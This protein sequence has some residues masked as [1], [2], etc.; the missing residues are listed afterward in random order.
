MLYDQ[1]LLIVI[2]VVNNS[3]NNL[4]SINSRYTKPNPYILLPSD[5]LTFGFQLP[6][7]ND[8]GIAQNSLTFATTGINKITLYGSSLRVNPETNQ[9]EEYHDTLNQLLSSNSIHEVITG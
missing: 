6:W 2:K 9:L 1:L 5:K 8:N 3:Y 4:I 7:D